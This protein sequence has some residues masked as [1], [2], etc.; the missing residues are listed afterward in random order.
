MS[1]LKDF[2]NYNFEPTLDDKIFKAF[3]MIDMANERGPEYALGQFK[4]HMVTNKE[5]GQQKT[6][7]D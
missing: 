3:E 4:E 7:F 2:G 1:E 5:A 6:I